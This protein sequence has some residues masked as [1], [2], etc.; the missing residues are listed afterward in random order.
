VGVGAGLST[1]QAANNNKI[2]PVFA[3]TKT[4]FIFMVDLLFIYHV[5]SSYIKY[6][7]ATSIG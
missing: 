7:P 5:N 2:R 3:I 6:F 4:F 1:L